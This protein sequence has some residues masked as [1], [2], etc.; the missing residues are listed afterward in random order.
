MFRV[1]ILHGRSFTEL[2]TAQSE[3]ICIISRRFAADYFK[4]LDPIGK[5]VDKSVVV[6]VVADLQHSE[7]RQAAP[8][9]LYEPVAQTS[10]SGLKMAHTWFSVNWVVRGRDATAQLSE[11]L[12]RE[13]KAVD[14]LQPFSSFVT[15][16]EVRGE[17]LKLDRFLAL[18]MAGF[19]LLALVLAAAGIYGVISYGV[20]QR[21]HEFGIRLALGATPRSVIRSI[22][23]H[24]LTLAAAGVCAGLAGAYG[25]SSL[26]AAYVF[27]VAP[28]D[29]ATLVTAAVFLFTV[30][31]LASLEPALRVSRLDPARALRVE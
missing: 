26:L 22:L 17:A 2:D 11:L 27:G 7:M 9:T 8:P 29:P 12:T 16:E 14:P 13:V 3:R 28:T 23:R 24:G 6:G 20:A 30:A 5:A 4:G 18:L 21:S 15:L 10:D 19:A 1:P 25:L 31:G